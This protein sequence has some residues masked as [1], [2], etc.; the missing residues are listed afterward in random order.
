[1]ASK[2][3]NF[4]LD[5]PDYGVDFDP[6][7]FDY[8]IRGQGARLVHYKGQRCPIGMSVL[9]DNRRPHDHHTGCS[10]GFIYTKS[11]SIT[12][13]MMGNSNAPGLKDLGWVAGASAVA[14]FPQNYDDSTTPFSL[15]P[16]DRF[17]ID[18]NVVVP[19]WQLVQSHETG[20]ERLQFPAVAVEGIV[21]ARGI[22]Y[23]PC[24]DFRVTSD[25]QIEWL[26]QK[27]PGIDLDSG[28]GTIC[29]IRYSYRPYFVCLRLMHEIRLSQQDLS[30]GSRGV[31]R[32]P[33]Q[34][35]LQREYLFLNEEADDMS[36][37]RSPRAQ[38]APESGGFGPR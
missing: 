10:N 15:C 25:G 19:T 26:G 8:R 7:A 20:L 23:A 21:D 35:L 36:N 37:P 12:A 14:T 16:F 29:S 31:M 32:M 4:G 9:G 11:G 3:D 6:D 2:N 38:K 24:A 13:L 18:E 34:A 30:D 33:Q 1:M 27:R 28:N 5:I 17:Y 22:T